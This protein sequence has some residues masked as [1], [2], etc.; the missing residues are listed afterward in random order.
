MPRRCLSF[1]LLILF[2]TLKQLS[3]NACAFN[4]LCVRFFVSSRIPFKGVLSRE[5][6]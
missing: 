5:K 6:N 4:F 3:F 2:D 1:V